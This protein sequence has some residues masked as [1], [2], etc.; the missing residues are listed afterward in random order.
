MYICF[1]ENEN[2]ALAVGR[3]STAQEAI[4]VWCR[5]NDILDYMREYQKWKPLIV[6]GEEKQIDFEVIIKITSPE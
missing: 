5:E 2:D 1:G 6:E 3:G 4:S